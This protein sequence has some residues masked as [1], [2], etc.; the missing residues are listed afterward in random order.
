LGVCVVIQNTYPLLIHTKFMRDERF[1]KIIFYKLQQSL[2]N[3]FHL[4]S[5]AVSKDYPHISSKYTA[6]SF[7]WVRPGVPQAQSTAEL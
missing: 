7:L 2:S 5:T 6:T 4:Y 1:L 3:K